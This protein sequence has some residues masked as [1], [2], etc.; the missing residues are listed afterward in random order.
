MQW[1][2]VL[3]YPSRLMVLAHKSGLSQGRSRAEFEHS[4]SPSIG[5]PAIPSNDAR[6]RRKGIIIIIIL[7]LAKEVGERW[8]TEQRKDGKGK[9]SFLLL[10]KICFPPT[11]LLKKWVHLTSHRS[12][13]WCDVIHL[14]SLSQKFTCGDQKL[15]GC[16]LTQRLCSCIMFFP[17]SLFFLVCAFF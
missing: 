10:K 15:L 6:G 2:P 8:T 1:E 13:V 4:S 14:V 12:A 5:L 16:D 17:F 7:I 11:H 9:Y 3:E